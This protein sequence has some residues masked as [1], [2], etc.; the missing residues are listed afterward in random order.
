MSNSIFTCDKLLPV[1]NVQTNYCRI[2]KI[3]VYPQSICLVFFLYSYLLPDMKVEKQ[4]NLK[5]CYR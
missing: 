5:Y 1:K 2:R 3:D 4:T